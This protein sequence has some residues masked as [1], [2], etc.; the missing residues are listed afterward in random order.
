MLRGEYHDNFPKR[1]RLISGGT[2]ETSRQ[3]WHDEVQD[4]HIKTGHARGDE[5][6]EYISSARNGS[7]VIDI[8][9]V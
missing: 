5:W 2:A 3:Q 7:N 1:T 9:T 4:S 6:R 8:E